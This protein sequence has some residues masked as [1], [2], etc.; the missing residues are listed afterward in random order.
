MPGDWPGS[1]LF[2]AYEFEDSVFQQ[3]VGQHLL[4][5]GVLPFQFLHALGLVD[6]HLAKLL[7]PPV[8]AHLREIMLSAY[9]PDALA[10]VYLP[11][12]P[13]LVF[14]AVSLSFH[15]LWAWLSQRL[16]H[17]LAQIREVT[18]ND[19]EKI[20]D[21]KISALLVDEAHDLPRFTYPHIAHHNSQNATY[22][23]VAC[24]R[25]QKLKYAGS[26]ARIIE[27]LDFTN[28]SNRLN[29]IYRNP[30][31]IYLASLSLMFRWFAK[32]GPK[33]IPSQYDLK[34]QF[35]LT[36]ASVLPE[37]PVSVSMKSDLHPANSWSHVVDSFP[38]ANT[39][40]QYL[41]REKL[42]HEEV[43]WV[44]FSNEDPNFNYEQ[45][46]KSFTYHNFRTHDSIE[47]CERTRHLEPG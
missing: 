42:D 21:L 9:L 43:L 10:G 11:Q 19:F 47:L 13:D 12:D 28:K 34:W 6:F 44:R 25:H 38:D 37:E 26:D 8:E 18:S 45:L 35:G 4:E 32:E 31:P 15:G 2:F 22:L 17:H 24:D 40:Y 30:A 39:A 33:I 14:C 41:K 1:E 29:K 20:K 36:S 46:N 23:V 5:L 16:T 7:L 27:G 3:A